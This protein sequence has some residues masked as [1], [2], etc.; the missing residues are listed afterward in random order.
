MFKKYISFLMVLLTGVSFSLILLGT[1]L[2]FPEKLVDMVYFQS[3]VVFFTFILQLGLRAGG[4]IHIHLDRLKTV[5]YVTSYVTRNCWK[6]GGLSSLFVV[7]IDIPF[8]PSFIILQA[9]LSY[10]QGLYVAKKDSIMIFTN[11]FLIILSIFVAGGLIVFSASVPTTTLQIEIFSIFLLLGLSFNKVRKYRLGREKKLFILLINRYKGLQ[12]SSYI[13]YLTAFIFAQIFVFI[14]KNNQDIISL[15]ADVVL[16]SGLQLMVASK[17]LVF[18]EGDIIKN[19]SFRKYI[20]FYLAWCIL[21]SFL[22]SFMYSHFINP[23]FLYTV[24][25]LSVVTLSKLA[26]SFC[27][28]FVNLSA[29]NYIYK[30]GLVPVVIYSLLYLLLNFDHSILNVSQLSVILCCFSGLS[31]SLSLLVLDGQR[32]KSIFI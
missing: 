2:F 31:L 19:K 32:Q 22:F 21:S 10:L 8:Y 4:R 20:I 16:V 13:V 3:V 23:N 5:D 11:S 14:G 18:I 28:Q 1:R 26:F 25:F 27:A 12:Y 6:L 7:L 17:I 9:V 29:R 24:F 30:L 15:Y